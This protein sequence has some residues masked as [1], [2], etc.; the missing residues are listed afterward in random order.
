MKFE[1]AL[2]GEKKPD[3]FSRLIMW[4]QGTPYSHIFIII[5]GI[6]VYHSIEKGTC[7]E[8]IDS[9]LDEHHECHGRV[10]IR[11]AIDNEFSV[12]FAYGYLRGGL[13]RPYSVRECLAIVFPFLRPF[14][15]KG[16]TEQ[17]C[18]EYVGRWMRDGMLLHMGDMD[19]DWCNPKEVFALATEINKQQQGVK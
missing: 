8:H 6:F 5:D 1:V 3:L 2:C 9:V 12:G 15:G 7:V 14:F 11:P 17:K 10:E 16:A 19:M 13:D 18:S 4:W